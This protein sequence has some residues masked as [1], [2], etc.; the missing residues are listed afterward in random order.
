MDL[1]AQLAGTH[2]GLI[3][4]FEAMTEPDPD[5]RPQSAREVSEMLG[6]SFDRKRLGPRKPPSRALA[7]RD[8]QSMQ[9]R[10]FDE[11]GDMLDSVPV[12]ISWLLRIVLGAVALGGYIGVNVLRFV[13]L[14]IVFVLV[15][16]IAGSKNRESIDSAHDSVA[17]ALDEGIDGFRTL[18][19]RCLPGGKRKRQRALP[20]GD[21][22]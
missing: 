3:E 17:G 10:P 20:K 12:P 1:R 8:E 4:V 21:D 13:A 6:R 11:L 18:G 15:G 7:K 14:P 2:A 22:D 9:A 5:D 16:I 19:E